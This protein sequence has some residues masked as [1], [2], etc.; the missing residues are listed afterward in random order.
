M[1]N[2]DYQNIQ[3]Q[4]LTLSISS[5]AGNWDGATNTSSILI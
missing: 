5:G 2:R 1:I 3:M 4:R